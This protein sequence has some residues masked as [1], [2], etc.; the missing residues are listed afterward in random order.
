MALSP[1]ELGIIVVGVAVGY[2][3]VSYLLER[4]GGKKQGVAT[5]ST[6]EAR[7]KLDISPRAEAP[8][9]AVLGVAQ[10]ASRAEI[11]Q[12]Y[13]QRIGEF[14]PD[15][16]A[17]TNEQMRA[18]AVRRTREIEAAYEEALRAR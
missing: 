3:I 10:D 4:R 17:G 1:H 12:A 5:R 9:W 16:A 7:R 6:P 11:E 15:E 2:W 13:R 14:Q 18:L 8:W